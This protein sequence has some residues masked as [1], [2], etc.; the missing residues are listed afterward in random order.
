MTAGPDRP[1]SGA[2]FTEFHRRLAFATTWVSAF[3]LALV[4]ALLWRSDLSAGARAAAFG[5]AAATMALFVLYVRSTI[6]R[7]VARLEGT[8]RAVSRGE[9]PPESTTGG[10]SIETDVHEALKER[11]RS[12]VELAGV[13]MPILEAVDEGIST[14][15]LRKVQAREYSIAAAIAL[16]PEIVLDEP[17]LRRGV[18][19]RVLDVSGFE[20]GAFLLHEGDEWR[21]AETS[22][23]PHPTAAAAAAVGALTAGGARSAAGADLAAWGEARLDPAAAAGLVVPLT[24]GVRRRGAVVAFSATQRP[25]AAS[26]VRL[27]EALGRE[28]AVALDVI[29][30]YAEVRRAHGAS[31]EALSRVLEARD[32]A[33]PGH[34]A[35]TAELADRLA[36]R[37]DLPASERDAIRIAAHIHDVGKIGVSDLVLGKKGELSPDERKVVE[38]HAALGVRLLRLLSLSDRLSE[39]VLFHHERWDGKGYPSGKKGDEIPV[40]ARI[41]AVCEAFDAM[42]THQVYREAID[43][44]DAVIRLEEESGKQF[45]PVVVASLRAETRGWEELPTYLKS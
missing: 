26:A 32:P 17:R 4:A 29:R 43:M 16:T 10:P 25:V 18:L 45:D 8:I 11:L 34:A 24:A 41:I 9:A 28:T 27:L 15:T 35:R 6:L 30:A 39:I 13:P 21:A 2:G 22:G 40:G 44:R 12:C 1:P 31:L 5:A 33:G 23:V 19:H 37:L 36:A 42:V 14:R 3:G 20:K 7:P 38:Q